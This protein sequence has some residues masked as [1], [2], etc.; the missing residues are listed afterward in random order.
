MRELNE[1]ADCVLPI[2]NQA[3]LNIVQQKINSRTNQMKNASASSNAFADMNNIVAHLLTNLTCS[4]RFEGSL[5]IDLN[6]ITTNLVP[7]PKL[8][9]LMTSMSP[10]LSL[11]DP[12]T[13]PRRFEQMFTDVFQR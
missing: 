8:H 4:M 7:Y 5:N 12:R 1:H 6:E 11:S 3:L 10:L 13:Q 2:E 9:Y